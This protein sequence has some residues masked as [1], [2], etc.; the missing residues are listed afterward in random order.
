M[1]VPKVDVIISSNVFEH[2]SN[3][4]E[5]AKFLLE[6]CDQFY[7]FTPYN[8]YIFKDNEHV[9]SYREDYYKNISKN[10]HTEIFKVKGH[11]E[12]WIQ[13]IYNIHIKNIF[14]KLL[15]KH[16]ARPRLQIM[17]LLSSKLT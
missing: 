6:K 14:R 12:T 5:I 7:I 17:H 13:L 2:L 3:D 9:N 1:D 11:S 16:T 8:E 4:I 10:I 15:N